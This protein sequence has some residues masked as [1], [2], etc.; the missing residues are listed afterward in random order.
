MKALPTG[1]AFLL[2]TGSYFPNWVPD[3]GGT[4]CLSANFLHGIRHDARISLPS[5][6]KLK[7]VTVPFLS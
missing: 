5:V 1:S 6:R 4:S 3:L 7:K 2:G